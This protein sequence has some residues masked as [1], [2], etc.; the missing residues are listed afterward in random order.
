M[1]YCPKCG[2]QKQSETRHNTDRNNK[3]QG[4]RNTGTERYM[5]YINLCTDINFKTVEKAP[6]S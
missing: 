3:S 4:K 5:E 2:G 1:T 6:T